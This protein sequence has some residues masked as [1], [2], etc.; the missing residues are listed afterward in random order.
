MICSRHLQQMDVRETGLE[1]D[2]LYLSPF[3]NSGVTRAFFHS[4]GTVPCLIDVSNNKLNA[5]ASS[6]ALSFKKRA[7]ISSGPVAL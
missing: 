5:G 1:F 7:E 4:S 3:L 2:G 6:S